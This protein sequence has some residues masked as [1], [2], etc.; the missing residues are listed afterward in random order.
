MKRH[1]L[2]IILIFILAVLPWAVFSVIAEGVA[3]VLTMEDVSVEYTPDGYTPQAFADIE[4]LNDE[5]QYL[6]ID[7]ESSAPVSI[8]LVNAGKYRVKAYI[9]D[10]SGTE[11][12]S[13][14]S[15]VVITPVT[16]TVAVEYLTV[17]YTSEDVEPSYKILPEW[18]AE[19]I[20]IKTAYTYFGED[21]DGIRFS[22]SVTAPHDLGT[23]LTLMDDTGSNGNFYFAGKAF[24]FTVAERR[25]K[26]QSEAMAAQSVD[27]TIYCEISDSTVTYSGYTNAVTC[28]CYPESLKLCIEYRKI[29]YTA[30]TGASTVIPPT[31]PGEYTVTASLF[32][33]VLAT[34]TVVI[35]KIV[36]ELSLSKTEYQYMPSGVFP[37]VPD[38]SVPC[39]FIAYNINEDGSTGSRTALPLTSLGTYLIVINPVDTDHYESVYALNY[40]TVVKA[41]AVITTA[42]Q[43]FVYDGFEKAISYN[44]D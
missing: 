26:K 5:I 13:V 9:T 34:G 44:V 22:Q 6:A 16:V 11:L 29:D 10:A 38:T 23:Y 25:G 41:T 42:T 7:V 30:N 17:A 32:D 35:N 40:I 24:I 27:P 15:N 36:P 2:L 21:G 33:T 18:A 19:Y 12:A 8:P 31:E 1:V 39:S 14:S 37:T 4:S 43:S 3:P 20:N 28:K